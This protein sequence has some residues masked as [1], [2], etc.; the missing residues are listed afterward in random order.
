M[1]AIGTKNCYQVFWQT[2]VLVVVLS[3]SIRL[4]VFELTT[5]GPP[6]LVTPNPGLCYNPSQDHPTTG[7]RLAKTTTNQYE[8]VFTTNITGN[9]NGKPTR[10][11][12]SILKSTRQYHVHL[13]TITPDGEILTS[14]LADFYR[15]TA[16]IHFVNRTIAKY[17]N[18]EPPL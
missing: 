13:D 3:A 17:Q 8:T 12:I 5:P 14:Q 15:E 18:P 16:A 7:G 1:P 6:T 11:T 4:L 2:A 10:K 9:R